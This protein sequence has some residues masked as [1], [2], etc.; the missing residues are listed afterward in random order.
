MDE[1][2]EVCE[3]SVYTIKMKKNNSVVKDKYFEF[4]YK[5]V[6]LCI[7]P[8]DSRYFFSMCFSHPF[9]GNMLNLQQHARFPRVDMILWGIP[10]VFK[11]LPAFQLF[12][13]MSGHQKSTTLGLRRWNL[14]SFL[15]SLEVFF[16]FEFWVNF[17]FFHCW[18]GV[19]SYVTSIMYDP[20]KI[21]SHLF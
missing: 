1:L 3:N 20:G 7:H 11:Q 21:S 15:A 12:N 2:K 8:Y 18:H 4:T 19:S 14:G 9:L 10:L 16:F 5:V 13:V 17:I 6:F